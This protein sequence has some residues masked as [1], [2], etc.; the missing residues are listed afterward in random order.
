VSVLET[1]AREHRVFEE[2]IVRLERALKYPEGL[3]RAEW[4]KTFLVLL[5]ALD[6]HEEI[7]NIVFEDPAYLSKEGARRLLGEVERQHGKISLLRRDVLEALGDSGLP[8]FPRLGSLISQLA[9]RLRDHFRAEETRLWP[10]Y[11]SAMSRSLDRSIAR[12]VRE[13]LRELKRDVSV[14]DATV[15]D[16][17]G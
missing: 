7:E 11:R 3:A 8:E 2:L 14:G 5:P 16:Y 9:R 1:L 6:R 4:K 13:K 12:R 10:H 15:A 17:I